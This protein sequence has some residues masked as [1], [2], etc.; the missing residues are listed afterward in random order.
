MTLTRA[1]PAE[2]SILH[3]RD[4]IAAGIDA[5][6]LFVPARF[7]CRAFSFD[8]LTVYDSSVGP[9]ALATISD[10]RSSGLYTGFYEG[11][12]VRG[13]MLEF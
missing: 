8:L 13:I 11:L 6:A 1:F 9:P 12:R 4:G 10:L 3:A 2:S 7:I 5:V